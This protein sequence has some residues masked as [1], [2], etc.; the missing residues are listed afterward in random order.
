MSA[1]P[2]AIILADGLP[3]VRSALRLLLEQ[4]PAL[5]VVAEAG[6]AREL[7][8]AVEKFRP[9]LILVDWELPGLRSTQPFS[10]IRARCPETGMIALSSRPESRQAALAAGADA[11]ISK[12][13]SPDR[14]LSILHSVLEDFRSRSSSE[15]P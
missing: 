5:T 3:Q 1:Y 8:M 4:D 12:G 14:L 15:L 10:A 7:L 6:S 2:E 9:A 11:F 13:D